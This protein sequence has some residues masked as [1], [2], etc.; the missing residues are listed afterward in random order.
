MGD[1]NVFR[2][3]GEKVMYFDVFE[4]ESADLY[5]VGQVPL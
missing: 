3:E 1:Y 5:A 4:K 2:D